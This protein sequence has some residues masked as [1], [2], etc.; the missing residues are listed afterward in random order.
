VIVVALFLLFS[1]RSEEMPAPSGAAS[2]AAP[3]KAR[4][5]S[6]S[7]ALTETLFA[8]GAGPD[9]VGVSNYCKLPPEVQKLPK[10]GTSISPSYEA[11]A[12][13]SPTLIVTEAAVNTKNQ[14]LAR[15]SKVAG[16]PW[17]TVE[18]I[19]TGVTE[20]GKLTS[21]EAEA[22]KL[23]SRFNTE[24]KSEPPP[25]APQVLLVL[26]Y[27]PGPLSEVWYIRKNSLHGAA[28]HAAGAKNAIDKPIS[29]QPRLSLESLIALD[30]EHVI[31]LS[32]AADVGGNIQRAWSELTALR[33]VKNGR[34]RVLAAPEA[35]ANGPRIFL[36]VKRLEAELSRLQGAR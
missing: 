22:Q 7:P 3:K 24:L 36:L 17:L 30:P 25:D 6:L 18:Q 34:V 31:V 32:E 21:C 11:I 23:A 10:T 4:I 13:L 26:G 12:R 14:Q 15:L 35:F 29:G 20:L 19:A 5:V 33:A 1:C 8:I 2:A 9:V 16:L 28:L 27:R